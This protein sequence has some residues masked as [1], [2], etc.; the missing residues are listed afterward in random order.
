MPRLK[1]LS[2]GVLYRNPNPGFKAEYAFLPNI[3]PITETEVM[4]FYRIGQA[5]YSVDGKLSKLR[6]TDGDQTWTT[7]GEVWNP[8]NDDVPYNYS[9]PHATRFSDGSMGLVASRVDFADPNVPQTNPETG[10]WRPVETIL[11]R[12]GDDGHTWSAPEP[13]EVTHSEIAAPPSQIIELNDGRWWLAWEMWKAW[14][15]TSPLHIKTFYTISDDKGATWSE[16]AF[17]ESASDT[18]KMYSHARYARMLDGRIVALQWAQDIGASKDFDLHFTISDETGTEWSYPTP[19]GIMG[20]TSWVADMG[21]GVLAAAYTSRDRMSPGIN[22]VL[23]EDEGRTWDIESQVMVWDAIGQEYLGVVQ[24]PTYPA[25]HDNIAFGKPNAARLLNGE[26]ICS[27][28]CTQA[29]VTHTRFARLA[30]D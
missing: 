4:C 9:S 17:F 30:V 18:E 5:F 25:S 27:W 21:D 7:E 26:L 13:V 15:D 10:G 22:V 23:S 2:D 20:Q 1:L 12:S 19:T 24:K 3:V 28:W 29:C 14:D 6:S 11:F 8:A 16:P